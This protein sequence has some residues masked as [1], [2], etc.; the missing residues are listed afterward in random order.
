MVDDGAGAEP[1]KQV[2]QTRGYSSFWSKGTLALPKP[3]FW[4][5]LAAAAIL[6]I[7]SGSLLVRD[8]RLSQLQDQARSENEI[9]GRRAEELQAQ[10]G[11]KQTALSEKQREMINCSAWPDVRGSPAAPRTNPMLFRSYWSP[12]SRD[13]PCQDRG[14]SGRS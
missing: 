1:R 14:Y 3:A 10:L 5:A 9:L 8:L 11:E 7:A 2:E 4:L 12:N 13:R 6:L